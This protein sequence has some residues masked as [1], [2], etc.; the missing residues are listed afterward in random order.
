MTQVTQPVSPEV[1]PALQQRY[2][3]MF[4]HLKLILREVPQ[5]A[6]RNF[7]LALIHIME[8]LFDEAIQNLHL[9]TEAEPSHREA[10]MLLSDIYF[11]SGHY[12]ES[13]ATFERLLRLDP[14]DYSVAVWLCFVYMQLGKRGKELIQDSILNDLAPDLVDRVLAR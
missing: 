8:G 11:K 1:K 3:W 10:L 14:S 12:E 5:K 4:E 2:P 13:R 7:G 9:T 6:E